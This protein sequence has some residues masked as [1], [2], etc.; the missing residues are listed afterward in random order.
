MPILYNTGDWITLRPAITYRWIFIFNGR[1]AC[2][3]LITIFCSKC[4]LY[5]MEWSPDTELL[6]MSVFAAPYGGPM[7]IIRDAKEFVKLGGSSVKPIIRIFT[8]S[9]NLISSINVRATWKQQKIN[10]FVRETY[11][12]SS[13]LPNSGTVAIC[14][15]WDGPTRKNCCVCKMM[16]SFWFTTCS[17]NTSTHLAW[18]KRR[19][20]PK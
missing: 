6:Q 17:A 2:L 1:M 4:E 5:S 18:A 11:L 10:S 12:F 13:F 7:A 20:T 19:K 8:A 16:A 9:G 14:W 15:H 3:N